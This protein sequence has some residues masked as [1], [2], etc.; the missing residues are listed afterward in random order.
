VTDGKNKTITLN[1]VGNNDQTFTITSESGQLQTYTVHV[2]KLNNVADLET[3]TLTNGLTLNFEAGTTTYDVTAPYKTTSTT[4]GATA[5]SGATVKS[6]TGLFELT[7]IAPTKNTKQV[8]VEAENCKTEYNA[9]PGNTCTEKTYTIN[10]TRTA[11]STNNNA[12]EVKVTKGAQEY[13]VTPKGDS[14]FDVVVPNNIS[15][16]TINVTAEDTLATVSA[17]GKNG[18]Q[19]LNVIGNNDYTFKITS[20]SGVEKNTQFIHI[21]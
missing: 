20:E 7:N 11:A 19:M 14:E 6:G 18:T 9:V 15:D 17:E 21:D 10:V 3:L 16:V 5:V 2:Y 1:N 8:V 4:V 12:G 13:T